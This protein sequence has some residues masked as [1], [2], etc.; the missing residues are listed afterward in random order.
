MV[1]DILQEVAKS[2]ASQDSRWRPMRKASNMYLLGDADDL[3]GFEGIYYIWSSYA[4][5]LCALNIAPTSTSLRVIPIACQKWK[6]SSGYVPSSHSCPC[7]TSHSASFSWFGSYILKR[8]A[9]TLL[10]SS[11]SEA[12]QVRAESISLEVKKKDG[13]GDGLDGNR[14]T[15]SDLRRRHWHHCNGLSG[16]TVLIDRTIVIL[17]EDL[18]KYRANRYP[19]S[20][21]SRPTILQGPTSTTKE[22][23]AVSIKRAFQMGWNR[24]EP[25]VVDIQELSSLRISHGVSHDFSLFLWAS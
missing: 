4:I 6:A 19:I 16:K 7:R 23:T 18:V 3:D 11:S 13:L 14:S 5:A 1:C 10:F 15:S 8:S 24:L 22:L 17:P 20:R 2:E 21:S 9:L 25:G 12:A